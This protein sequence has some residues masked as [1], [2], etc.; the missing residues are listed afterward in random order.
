MRIEFTLIGQGEIPPTTNS[1][2]IPQK[3]D[4]IDYLHTEYVVKRIRFLIAGDS[5]RIL[6]EIEKE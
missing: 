5:T 4:I 6:V 1:E 3:G 2:A